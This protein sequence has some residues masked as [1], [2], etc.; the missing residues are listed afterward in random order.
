MPWP[1]PQ[2]LPQSFTIGVSIGPNNS[3]GGSWT[4]QH[5]TDYNN[6]KNHVKAEKSELGLKGIDIQPSRSKKDTSNEGH[7]M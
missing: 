1:L 7:D 2:P 3:V 5:P 6:N 4:K